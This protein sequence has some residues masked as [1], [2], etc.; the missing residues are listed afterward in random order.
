MAVKGGRIGL[1]V[2][3]P[4]ELTSD[5]FSMTIYRDRAGRYFA[6]FVV[7][8]EVAETRLNPTGQ[9]TGLDV[10]LKMFATTEDERRDISNPRY[11]RQAQKALV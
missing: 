10:G 3:W 9:V 7:S 8:I 4:R 1:R 2:C 11:L 6:S 5:P